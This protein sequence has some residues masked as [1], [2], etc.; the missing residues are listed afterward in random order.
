M[1]L[2][3]LTCISRICL[4]SCSMW[5][6][7]EGYF[8]R[9][10]FA[11]CIVQISRVRIHRP[12]RME[13]RTCVRGLP[14]TATCAPTG[15]SLATRRRLELKGWPSSVMWCCCLT[16]RPHRPAGTSQWSRV[17]VHLFLS[18]VSSLLCWSHHLGGRTHWPYKLR[19]RGFESW[20]ERWSKMRF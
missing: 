1:N 20:L 14:S 6:Q 10:S 15:V 11:L 13:R 2:D 8:T 5:F 12:S 17:E 4:S 19:D 9:S 16:G 3:N 7:C 18:W